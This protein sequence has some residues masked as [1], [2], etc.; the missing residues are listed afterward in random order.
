MT[1]FS[2]NHLLKDCLQTQSHSEVLGVRAST[3]E[4]TI[5]PTIATERKIFGIW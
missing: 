4:N 5:Q 2:L 1:S 3:Y